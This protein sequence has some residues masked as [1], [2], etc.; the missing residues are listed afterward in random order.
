VEQRAKAHSEFWGPLA[1]FGWGI[2]ILLGLVVSQGITAVVYLILTSGEAP[3]PGSPV[4]ESL[5]FDGRLLSWCTF[6]SAFV[7]VVAILVV[8]KLKRGSNLGDY[9]GLSWP[10]ARQFFLWLSVL[11]LFMAACDGF[12]IFLG[13]PTTPE[14]MVKTYASLQ[15][16]LILWVALLVAAPLSEELF[17]RGFLLKGLSASVL[18]WYGAVL[19]SA[20]MWAAIHIQYDLYGIATVLVLGFILGVARIK[21]G[22]VI[23]TMLLHSLTNLLATAEVVI[24]LRH[25]TA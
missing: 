17:F 21:S 16:P 24:H 13:K 25:S 4:L 6:A 5:K 7:S 12:S 23:L 22:S 19:I 9:L 1:T 14:F 15:S 2:L 11:V 18:K 10:S 8:V 20:A 3:R